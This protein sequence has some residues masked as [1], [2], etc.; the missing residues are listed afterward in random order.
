MSAEIVLCGGR[1]NASTIVVSQVNDVEVMTDLE[2]RTI[3]VYRRDS[4]S[5]AYYWDKDLSWL[6]TQNFD[7]VY[8]KLANR[9]RPLQAQEPP[10]A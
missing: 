8:A 9:V 1:Y 7:T 2:D 10:N 6:Y 4:D 3:D 5:L